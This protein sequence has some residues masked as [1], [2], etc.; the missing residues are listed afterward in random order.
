MEFVHVSQT[1]AGWAAL[2][3]G[4]SGIRRFVLPRRSRDEALT[5]AKEGNERALVEREHDHTG[6]ADQVR[7]YFHGEPVRFDL[8]LDFGDAGE[9]D[10]V[11]WAAAR[12]IGYGETRSYG[13]LADRIGKPGAARAVGQALGRN[14][15]PLIV[16]CHRILRSNGDLGGFG[17]GLDWKIRLLSIERSESPGDRT[18]SRAYK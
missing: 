8:A 6:C 15:I 3:A 4:G 13:W 12:E 17:A 11:V 7:A 5:A 14:P 18:P 10:R 2:I 16:P 9:F 1:D